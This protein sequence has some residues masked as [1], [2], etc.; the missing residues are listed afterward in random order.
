MIKEISPALLKANAPC[1]SSVL[2]WALSG[3]VAVSEIAFSCGD[4]ACLA[5]FAA[6][7][8]PRLWIS[9]LGGRQTNVDNYVVAVDWIRARFPEV[10]A[11]DTLALVGSNDSAVSALLKNHWFHDR[12]F[13][14]ELQ[15]QL[16]TDAS[17]VQPRGEFFLSEASASMA[18][19]VFV[20]AFWDQ[21]EWYFREMGCIG[22]PTD[23]ATLRIANRYMGA[24]EFI[25]LAADTQGPVAVTS[26]T[27]TRDGQAEFHTG[28]G[29]CPRARRQGLGRLLVERTLDWAASRGA[30][31][32]RVRT[33]RRLTVNND[34]LS[35]YEGL[36][37]VPV[38]SFALLRPGSNA[39]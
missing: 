30:R 6:F 9:H 19:E 10:D 39:S 14:V 27:L 3:D 25:L 7:E 33:Q 12:D 32:V 37:A 24:A 20:A 17:N 22:K 31:I 16:P 26:A 15:W 38:Q 35:M 34:N 36:G 1:H 21:W 28:V 5:V 11:A 29:I 4:V 18:A 13:P 23:S 8:K 2:L